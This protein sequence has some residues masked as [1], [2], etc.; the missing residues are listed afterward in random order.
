MNNPIEIV[1]QFAESLDA[2]DYQTSRALLSEQCEYTCREKLYCGPVAIIETYREAGN[3][4]SCEFET[5][6]YES[7]VSSVTDHAALIHFKDH[8]S[9]QG[10]RLTF[11]CHQLVEIDEEGMITRIEHRDL[12]GQREALNEFRT[13]FSSDG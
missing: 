2:E 4:A 12:P 9:H 10:Q 7:S 13:R 6:E 1:K 11:E 8:L 3:T 5:I